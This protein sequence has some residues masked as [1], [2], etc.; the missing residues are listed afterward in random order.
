MQRMAAEG[1][2]LRNAHEQ[3][4]PGG[5]QGPRSPNP[6]MGNGT[7][8]ARNW[9]AFDAIVKSLRKLEND[10]TLVV[11]SGKPVGVFRTTLTA[12]RVLIANA[13]IVP[14]WA[15]STPTSDNWRK[16]SHDAWSND[17]SKLDIHWRTG[18]LQGP[19]QTL[20]AVAQRHFEVH[21]EGRIVLTSGLG[22][23]GGAQPLAVNMMTA[24]LW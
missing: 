24:S 8:L 9:P 5:G 14:K 2:A 15:D 11:Q 12:P 20:A 6:C 10:E 3:L 23:M 17:S 18:E 13:L 19:T 4:G 7:G 22:E 21:L 1:L 16:R